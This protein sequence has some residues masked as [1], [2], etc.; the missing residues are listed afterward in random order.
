VQFIADHGSSML[1]VRQWRAQ[2][3]DDPQLSWNCD[4]FAA[5]LAAPV[6]FDKAGWIP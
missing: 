5:F 4:S 3:W 1:V 6:G 2:L